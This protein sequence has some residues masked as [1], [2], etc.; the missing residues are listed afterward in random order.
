[1]FMLIGCNDKS[2][3]NTLEL[4]GDIYIEYEVAAFDTSR[5]QI[6][7][8]DNYVMHIDGSPY[9]GSDGEVPYSKMISARVVFDN[10]IVDLDVSGMYNA[11]I[12]EDNVDLEFD[13]SMGL[14]KLWGLFSDGAG[15]YGT[16]W[17]LTRHNSVRSIIT[18]DDIT[19]CTMR[20]SEVSRCL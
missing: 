19:I 8:K 17:L 11:V 18:N 7:R 2:H 15:S 10:H 1:M 3:V 5:H 4:E 12:N 13:E 20:Y 9:W 6:E 16:L 14:Y